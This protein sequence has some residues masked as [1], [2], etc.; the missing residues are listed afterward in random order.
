MHKMTRIYHLYAMTRE[1]MRDG[2]DVR[3]RRESR[4]ARTTDKERRVLETRIRRQCGPVVN[5]RLSASEQRQVALPAPRGWRVGM[6][7]RF[8][9]LVVDV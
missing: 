6:H 2:L 4:A 5:M 3:G 1:E 8:H 9:M 7:M